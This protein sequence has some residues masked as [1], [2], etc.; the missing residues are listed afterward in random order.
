MKR[1]VLSQ[2]VGTGVSSGRH[3]FC[4]GWEESWFLDA[5]VGVGLRGLPMKDFQNEFKWPLS[6][7]LGP[8][9]LLTEKCT[10]A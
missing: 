2:P 8:V 6:K 4:I 3:F 10:A 5:G 1:L 9:D 7:E